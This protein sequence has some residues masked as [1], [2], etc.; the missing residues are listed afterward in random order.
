MRSTTIEDGNTTRYLRQYDHIGDVADRAERVLHR[1]YTDDCS[2]INGNYS[3]TQTESLGESM[4]LLRYGWQEG[5]QAARELLATIDLN[6]ITEQFPQRFAQTIYYDTSGQ[7][8]DLSRFLANDPDNMVN[9]VPNREKIGSIA[10]IL[11]NLSQHAM[12]GA[13]RMRRRGVVVLG[14]VEA[15]GRLG[16]SAD[17]QGYEV[18]TPSRHNTESVYEMRIPLLSAGTYPNTDTVAFAISHPS[19]LRR[20]M[21]ALE[22]EE[23]NNIRRRFGFHDS[24]GYGVPWDLEAESYE[25]SD[26]IHISKDEALCSYDEEMPEELKRMLYE[27]FSRNAEVEPVE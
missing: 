20:I 17:V 11:I 3:F 19:F 18:S 7:E 10:N 27:L 2:S 9:V 12:V 6:E 22:E 14:L 21:F 16:Y 23:P 5:A 24:G 26:T 25:S 1:D 13:D 15:L 4:E 8:P